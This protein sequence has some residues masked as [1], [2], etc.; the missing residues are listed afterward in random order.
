MSIHAKRV[1]E[2]IKREVSRILSMELADPRMGFATVSRVS[3]TG[4]F[5]NAT[6]YISVLD[7]G[8]TISTLTVLNKAKRR[9]RWLLAKRIRVRRVPDI[10]F[11]L[12]EHYEG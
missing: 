4:D 3:L 2:E 7:A 6:I 9:I 12:D 1:E 5:R 11:C 8:Q 10:A